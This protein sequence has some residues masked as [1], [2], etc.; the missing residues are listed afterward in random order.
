MIDN[1][2]WISDRVWLNVVN[3]DVCLIDIIINYV[4]YIS[5]NYQRYLILRL[6]KH[7]LILYVVIIIFIGSVWVVIDVYVDVDR[8]IIYI[9]LIEIIDYR[10]IYKLNNSKFLMINFDV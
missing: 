2:W 8:D 1:W 7:I 10:L 4:M 5:M 3:V 9:Y 6:V